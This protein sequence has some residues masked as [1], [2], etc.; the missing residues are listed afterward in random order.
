MA[1]TTNRTRLYELAP[2]YHGVITLQMAMEAGVPKVELRKLTQRGALERVA[3]G[4]YR[5]PFAAVDNFS[6]MAERLASVGPDSYL[7]G[8]SVLSML[9]IGVSAPRLTEIASP[10]RFRGAALQLVKVVPAENGAEVETINGI[11]V[12]SV[13]QILKARRGRVSDERLHGE[14]EQA[15]RR[16]YVSDQA[17]DQLEALLAN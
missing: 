8:D 10:R 15:W 6:L 2:S 3:R 4:V 1:S 5:V 9:D 14:V 16:G 11:R 13:Y 17:R 12:Q 7:I